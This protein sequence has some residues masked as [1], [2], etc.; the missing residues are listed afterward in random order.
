[1]SHAFRG[2]AGDRC[3]RKLRIR[4]PLLR[5]GSREG[6]R[7]QQLESITHLMLSSDFKLL[8]KG[9]EVP[10]KGAEKTI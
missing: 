1:M 9:S 2:N 6:E 10:V 8:K 4:M 5:G 3:D 7:W